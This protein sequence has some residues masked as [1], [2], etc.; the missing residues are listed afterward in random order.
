M[1]K[2]AIA[3]SFLAF[4]ILLS[5]N[6]A[7]DEV[8]CCTNPGASSLTCSADRL[9]LR[10][11]ECCPK[12]ETSYTSYYKSQQNQDSPVNGNDCS[13]LFFFPNKACSAVEACA[14]GC[15]CSELGGL[16]APEARCK[17]TGLAFYKGE[18]NCNQLCPIPQCNDGI[19]NDNN[20]CSDFENGDLGC[21]SPA[22]K[23]ESGGSCAQEGAG[24]GNPGYLPKLSNLEI[25]PIKGQNK[26]SLKWKD[27]CSETAVSYDI[28][29]CK[30]NGCTN[31]AFVGTTNTNSFEDASGLMFDISYTYQIKARYN[32]Q[33]AIPT[34]TKTAALGNI[35]CSG[36]MSA[37]NFCIHEPYYTQYRNYLSSNFPNEFKSF[38]AGVRAKFSDRFNK[39]FFCDQSNRLVPEGTAC[40]QSQVCAV[41]SNKPACLSKTS[42]NYEAANPFGLF[43]TQQECETNKY[44]FYD[45][46][47]STVDSCFGCDTSMACYDYKTDEACTRDNCKVGNCKW[48]A[49]ASQLGV[50]VCM[51]ATE[52]NCQW[53]EKKGASSLENSRSFN[54]VFDFCTRD[55]SNAL[56]EGSFKCYFRS[57][58]SKN[59]NEVSCKDY[60]PEQ[61]SNVQI[62]H[63]G[64]NN[65]VNP[66]QDECGIKACQNINGACAKNSDGD[67][68]ADC[69]S[70]SCESD[71]FAPNTTLLPLMKKGIVDSLVIQIY[72]KT[73]VNSSTVLRNSEDYSTFMC[74]EPCGA[75]G[76]PYNTSLANKIV[77]ITNLNAFDGSSGNKL[78]SLADGTNVIR[79]Y[80]QDPAKNIEGVKKITIETHAKSDGP[81]VFAVNV[82]GASKILDKLYTSS[83]K[84][85]ITIQFFEPAA[86]TYARLT[87]KQTGLIVA[88]QAGTELSSRFT[89]SITET[90]P[91]GEYTLEVNAKDGN[92][93]FM[94]KAL[95]QIVII[96]N[97]K[98]LL[99]II[100]QNGEIFN[101]SF[102]AMKLAFDKDV[103]LNY[104][105]INSEDITSMFSTADSKVFTATVNLSD[106][107]KNLEVSAA[108]FAKNLVAGSASFIVDANPANIILASPRFGTASKFVFDIAVETDNDAACKYSLDNNFE[109]DFMD[110][111]TSTGGTMHS[112]SG[113][114]KIQNGDTSGHN[115]NIRCKDQRGISFRQ[116]SINVDTTPP[117][118]NGAFAFPNPVIEKP[119]ITT[120]TVDSDEKVVCRFS[121]TSKE[122][123]SM[124]GK[125]E[126][127]DD[128]NF[129]AINRQAITAENEGEYLYY[130]S[131]KNKA[132]LIS[133]TKEAPFKVDLTV[134]IS[135][136]SH[137]PEF[138]NSTN[139][140]LA[141]ETNKKSQCK[142]SETD[143][144][145]QNG[146]IFGMPSYSHTRQLTLMQ[147]K[148]TFYM[149]CKD[150]FLQKFSDVA[151]ISFTIDTTPP[152]I[153]SVND[154][155][156][157]E[158]NPE[159]TFSTD[160]LRVKWKSTDNESM[161]SS[162]I[163]SIIEYG[164]A[165]A[166]LNSTP[167]TANN[168]WVIATKPNST[169]LELVD[170]NKYFF[171]VRA[172]NIVGISSN[173][174][175]SDGIT[176]DSS[177]KPLN[178]TN[179]VKDQKE[180]DVDCG[181]GCDLC[182][183]GK[184]CSSNADCKTNFCNN[185]VCAAPNCDDSLRNQE[186]S[187]VDCGGQCKKCQ[188]NQA[189][190]SSSDCESG[191]CGF[192]F[193][194][195]QESC[196]DSRLSPGEAD[197]DCGGHCPTKC[198]EGKA[199]S[200][201]EDCGEALQCVAS[202]CK[203]CNDN[204]RNCNGIP[205]EQENI[206]TKDTDNDGMTDE[207]EIQNGLNPN[208]PSD[209]NS[210][211]DSDELTNLEEFRVADTYGKSTNPN[212]ADTDGDSFSDKEEIDNGT[213][214]VDP[215]DFPKSNLAKILGFVIGLAVLLSGFGYFAYKVMKK[216][217]MKHG[218]MQP[219]A[220]PK[221]AVRQEKQTISPAKREG[222]TIR[223]QLRKKEAQKEKERQ[224]LFE[225]FGRH[226]KT[227]TKPEIKKEQKNH[228]AKKGKKE[229]VFS[230]L[231]KMAIEKKPAKPRAKPKQKDKLENLYK[232][233]KSKRK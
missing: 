93:V 172:K 107:N 167:S 200:F 14:L 207:W 138:F 53:C 135:I 188:N 198:F 56:S 126:G 16:I 62:I 114:N 202:S 95:S 45:K 132:E 141:A 68:R 116:F 122:F 111:F 143:S 30:D 123:E 140:V 174:S 24:C 98:P 46:S 178:C 57:G 169:G 229:E 87:N 177:L 190:G 39:A 75:N 80:S 227:E 97:S 213:S 129:R 96:D 218:K 154:S 1:K 125:F 224:M 206:Q 120:L 70:S 165:R 220:M 54:E 214:P 228:D 13:S 133:T 84:P 212:L 221:I 171:R 99:A 20:G 147:G 83:Q 163:Y 37:S 31:F 22:D 58:K 82:T 71:Y 35:E 137:T 223:E 3:A 204:D 10:D 148:H 36:R 118:I 130:V 51:S 33:T 127:F 208:D 170:G 131:C 157:L 216:K 40:T 65:I 69:A 76:H 160:H 185:G 184:K 90:L 7:A 88:L 110:A 44:C 19:D 153:L 139:I 117:A 15:C 233:A 181:S 94:D 17:G 179:G 195:P 92:N 164:T 66:S 2:E 192:G 108:D 196:S 151:Q 136:I 113:F 197:I 162:H 115:L 210:D 168:E 47:H 124:D 134:P 59:C 63:D 176:V 175:E 18:T 41:S 112:I 149:V 5:M 230:K 150:Q 38:S 106:G 209:A 26:F 205:D 49:L 86:I 193:C 6:A 52:Y 42:C 156:T 25:T 28:L 89:F 191:Y 109:F 203:R 11:K 64:N 67:N 194:K 73:S 105:K 8:G 158:G 222:E 199:C 101:S 187:D 78:F 102:V 128:N 142:Y 29:R 180:A 183:T 104:V 232:L 225:P 61:C 159:F 145:A 85:S 189:C 21:T 81:R 152:V 161:V 12:P 146:D 103:T 32:L 27:E 34:I 226:E 119:S 100:P 215:E 91:N 186:E 201:N 48:K 72:D 79:Y 144:T 121:N 217:E 77:V 4:L 155:S 166:V 173:V 74:V 55:K 43:Y 50:G 23:D 9:A 182:G 211:S 219:M 60:D 231:T